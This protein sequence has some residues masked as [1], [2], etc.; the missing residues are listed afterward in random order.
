MCAVTGQVV[1]VATPIGNLGDITLRALEMLRTADWIYAEDTRHSQAL[2]NA[3]GVDVAGR[4]RSL[5]EHNER[6]RSQEIVRLAGE[7][8]VIAYVSDAGTPGISDPGA[9]LV[10]ACVAAE[11]RVEMLPGAN[12]VLPALVL[13][14]FATSA[15]TFFGFLDRKGGV[16]TAQLET[17]STSVSTSVFYESPRRLAA[18]LRDLGEVCGFDRRL[19]V[20][21]ELTKMFEQLSRGTVAEL[22]T[23]I[24]RG[25]LVTRGE[26]VV[27]VGPTAKHPSSANDLV[28][29]T[30]EIDALLES[31]MRTRDIADALSA[32]YSIPKKGVYEL[33]VA[34]SKLRSKQR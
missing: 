5:H 20:A 9:E 6:D 1:L 32:Q 30:A 12:A 14:G 24:D 4:L 22:L 15:F 18:T 8:A 13:S 26:C 33:A 27:V 23:A 29:V 28:V 16:R 7:G 34:R 25:D 3:H 2:F 10:K 19:A 11:I 21:R 17:I 31:G